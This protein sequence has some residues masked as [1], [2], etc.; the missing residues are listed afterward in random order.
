MAPGSFQTTFHTDGVAPGTYFYCLKG[1][2]F[3]ETRKM[4]VLK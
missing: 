1:N 3:N 2:G 4:V